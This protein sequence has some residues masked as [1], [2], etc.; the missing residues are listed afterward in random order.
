MNN[1]VHQIA[2]LSNYSKFVPPSPTESVKRSIAGKHI[3]W[4]NNDI[5]SLI[6]ENFGPEVLRAYTMVKANAIKADLARYCILYV[7]GG[8]YAD[9]LVTIDGNIEHNFEE[10][11][12][13]VFRD[14]TLP[15]MS[16]LPI[17]NG[18][19]WTKEK[20]NPILKRAIDISVSNI[21]N[22]RYPKNSHRIS[23]PVVFGTAI[24]E[25]CLRDENIKLLVGDLSYH[26]DQKLA[27]FTV[28][29][30]YYKKAMHFGWHRLPGTED[31]L[32]PGYQKGSSYTSMFEKRQLYI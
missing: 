9:L 2:I 16:V 12:M 15:D 29:N 6:K 23:G 32:P 4:K 1:L 7:H 8:W 22:K 14:I 25:A 24:A 20:N 10:V 18:L 17:V 26:N 30:W 31:E 3:L 11:D 5:V 28:H 27:E 13:I 19:F 21:L